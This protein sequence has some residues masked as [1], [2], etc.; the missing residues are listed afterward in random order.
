MFTY[1]N[2]FFSSDDELKY[3]GDPFCEKVTDSEALKRLYFD[4]TSLCIVLCAHT[5]APLQSASIPHT[6]HRRRHDIAPVPAKQVCMASVPA[7][8]EAKQTCMAS[9]PTGTEA[10]QTCMVSV[11]TGT[12]VKQT[13]M[14]SVPTGTEAKQT[15]MVSVPTGTEAKQTCMVSVPTGIKAK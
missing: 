2:L 6:R 13:C 10:K 4:I 15:Y 11:P 14:A 12:E 1:H 8:T 7:G 9:V 3:T 5:G